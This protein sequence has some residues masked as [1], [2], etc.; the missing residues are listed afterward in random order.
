MPRFRTEV[1]D[2]RPGNSRI[3]QESVQWGQDFGLKAVVRPHRTSIAFQQLQGTGPLP[4][5]Q[6]APATGPAPAAAGVPVTA[7]RRG[8]GA[9]V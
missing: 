8:E 1:T 2:M 3:A 4:P 6:A 5:R 9:R 7:E